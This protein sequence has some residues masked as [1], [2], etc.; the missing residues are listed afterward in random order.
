MESGPSQI[1]VIPVPFQSGDEAAAIQSGQPRVNLLRENELFPRFLQREGSIL[2]P[3]ND[4]QRTGRDQSAEVAHVKFAG[5]AGDVIA[6]AMSADADGG[7]KRGKG[8]AGHAG[9]DALIHRRGVN[10]GRSAA[11]IARNGNP[12]PVH[13]KRAGAQKI[14]GALN[15]MHPFA[16]E[17]AP[18]QKRRGRGQPAL[19]ALRPATAFPE[20]PFMSN[21]LNEGDSRDTGLDHF[22]F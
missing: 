18:Q 6:E 7:V 16:D 12:F 17:R 15:I 14:N 22:G 21:R 20:A 5:N 2:F 1:G 11:R 3:G 4:D 9:P 8:A 13:G 19:G 10:A